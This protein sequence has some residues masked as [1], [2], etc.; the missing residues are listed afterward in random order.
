MFVEK[1]WS[2]TQNLKS[3]LNLNLALDSKAIHSYLNFSKNIDALRDTKSVGECS[4]NSCVQ[5]NCEDLLYDP[6]T[7]ETIQNLDLKSVIHPSPS[8]GSS[9][10]CLFSQELEDSNSPLSDVFN[11]L[12]SHKDSIIY[13]SNQQFDFTAGVLNPTIVREFGLNQENVDLVSEGLKVN[14]KKEL[15]YS[16]FKPKPNNHNSVRNRPIVRRYLSSPEESGS[17]SGVNFKPLIESP[18]NL[19]PKPNGAPRLIHDL[20]HF[21]KFVSRGPK[22][23]HLNIF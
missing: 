7:D 21:N 10:D 11:M 13:D 12:S 15:D 16:K 20:S 22:V 18:L 3:L 2:N 8:Q 1:E 4:S 23:K 19:V 17:I 14:L 6:E 9:I 5:E